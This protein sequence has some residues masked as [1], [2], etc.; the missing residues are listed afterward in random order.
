LHS[1]T[2]D[3]AGSPESIGCHVGD[4]VLFEAKVMVSKL[5]QLRETVKEVKD[6]IEDLCIEFP[7]YPC[8]LS[9]PGFGPDVSSK[10]LGR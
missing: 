6:K 3:L 8:L 5:H 10:V 2:G 1:K 4:E 9:I 7:E